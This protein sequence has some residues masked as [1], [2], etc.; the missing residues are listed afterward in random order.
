MWL[1]KVEKLNECLELTETAKEM[2]ISFIQNNNLH[3][4]QNGRYELK[5]GNYV[6]DTKYNHWYNYDGAWC[7]MFV[8][9]CWYHA[10]LSN[11]LLVKYNAVF[12][13][14]Y[15]FFTFPL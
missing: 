12:N 2:I 10:G 8:S 3:S 6:N 5:N 11:D 13:K 4:L 15:L 7:A 9:W 1:G 14:L